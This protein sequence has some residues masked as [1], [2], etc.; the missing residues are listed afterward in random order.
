MVEIREGIL[1]PA[2]EI[3]EVSTA[4][5]KNARKKCGNDYFLTV[6]GY[7][8]MIYNVPCKSAAEAREMAHRVR[9]DTQKELETEPN[10][11]LRKE[12]RELTMKVDKLTK[13]MQDIKDALHTAME[14][15]RKAHEEQAGSAGRTPAVWDQVG[16]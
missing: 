14:E 15:E 7:T 12:I 2:S 3:A 9:M 5:R 13:Y 11:S 6:V 10:A 16:G 4:R 1:I 8:G